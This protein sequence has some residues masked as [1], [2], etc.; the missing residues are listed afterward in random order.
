MRTAPCDA[1]AR[2][3]FQKYSCMS[4]SVWTKRFPSTPNRTTATAPTTN[5]MEPRVPCEY[6]A[7]PPRCFTNDQII[8]R[9]YGE[10]HR[11]GGKR[12]MDELV[13]AEAVHRHVV[14]QS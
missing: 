13:D 9:D 5:A 3:K 4:A 7:G 11:D 10:D 6:S 8:G 1:S 2:L 14:R 12:E